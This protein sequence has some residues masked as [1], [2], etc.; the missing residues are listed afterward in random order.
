MIKG[1]VPVLLVF[2]FF[3]SATN[4]SEYEVKKRTGEYTVL[5]LIDRNPPVAGDN[6]LRVRLS[7]ASGRL[8]TDATVLVE[9]SMPP[10]IGMPFM[11][12]RSKTKLIGDI[13]T[14]KVTFCQPGPHSVELKITRGGRVQKVRFNVDA[15]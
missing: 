3:I 4:A 9:V 5:M 12:V 14:G 6:G 10:M 7:D 11:L 15:R 2:L 13:Y 1:V 8:V